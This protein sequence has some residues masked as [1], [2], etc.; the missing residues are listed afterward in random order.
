MC[1]LDSIGLFLLGKSNSFASFIIGLEAE[2]LGW[3]LLRWPSQK[4]Y[5]T[6]LTQP[7]LLLTSL[8]TLFF[9]VEVSYFLETILRCRALEGQ[10]IKLLIVLHDVST[11][12]YPLIMHEMN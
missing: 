11:T 5:L 1:F 6:R 2:S 9:I 7:L 10:Q 3:K 12:L 8:V 4:Y